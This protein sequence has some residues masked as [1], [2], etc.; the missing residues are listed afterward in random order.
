MLIRDIGLLAI[1]ILSVSVT[2]VISFSEST[3]TIET[4]GK[5]INKY[6]V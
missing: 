4:L 5:L 1:L 2:L 3:A 6:I